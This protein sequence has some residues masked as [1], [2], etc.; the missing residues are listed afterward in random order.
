MKPLYKLTSLAA[1]TLAFAQPVLAETTLRFSHS[2]TDGDT[3]DVWA[4]QIAEQMF[5]KTDGRVVIEVFPNQQLFK[6]KA[7]ADA[8]ARNRLDLAIYPLPWLSGRAPIAEI[9]ALP[10]LVTS[11]LDGVEWRQRAIWPMLQDAVADTGVKLVGSGWAMATI[12]TVGEAVVMP[13][14]L[15]GHKVRGLGVATEYMMGELGATVTSVP[16]SEIYQSLQTGVLS[17][18]LTIYSSFEG[19]SLKEV[20]DHLLVG[21]GFVGAMHAVLASPGLEKKIGSED[22]ATLLDV[23]EASEARF[24]E[25]SEQDN[26]RIVQAFSDAGVEVHTLT[27][28]QVAAWHQASRDYAWKYFK[29]KVEGG[30]AALEAVEQPL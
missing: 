12:G 17:G 23:I 21:P 7:Q 15:A 18:V 22:Y 14:D 9:G 1:L 16:A 20:T 4:D 6:A 25:Q 11:P 3:R 2:Y 10:G 27:E 5:E 28:E 29:E 24:A 8:V 26:A 19:Y 30:E 13:T